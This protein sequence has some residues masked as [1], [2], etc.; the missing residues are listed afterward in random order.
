MGVK[1]LTRFID[2]RQRL[3]FDKVKI[4]SQCLI[5]DGN[6]LIYFIFYSVSSSFR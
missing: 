6:A 1:G 2:E 4:A 5:I 3:L